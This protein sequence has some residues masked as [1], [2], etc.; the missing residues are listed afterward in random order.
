MEGSRLIATEKIIAV[1]SPGCENQ[2]EGIRHWAS[3]R[4][5]GF[6][7]I[8]T[9]ENFEEVKSE[10]EGGIV[11]ITIGGDGT[12]LEGARIFSPIRIP[13]IGVGSGTLSF[14]A[15]VE[16]EGIFDALEEI[17]A[18]ESKIDELQRV[19]VKIDSFEAEGLNEVVIGHIWPKKPIE[20]KISSIDVFVEG[21]H[22]GKYEGTGVAITTP[23]GSTGLS[24]SAGGPIHHPVL[25][26]TIQLTPL[27]T[28]NIG[29]RPLVFGAETELKII[30]DTEVYV[31]VDG[32]RAT[33]LL[34]TKKVITITGSKVPAYLINTSQSRGFFNRLGTNL[35]WGIR[36]QIGERYQMEKDEEKRFEETVLELA[37]SVAKGA[38]DVLREL[39]RKNEIQ[40]FENSKG[41][42]V[43]EADYLSENII[44]S[45]IRNKFPDH[46]IVS[47]ETVWEDKNSK[48]RWVIDPLD[49]T[50]N[51]I[52]RN[53]NYAVSV[54]LLEENEPLVGV[55]YI[56]EIDQ[57]YSAVRGGDAMVN[58][59]VIATTDRGE[60][61]E[62]ML[63]TGHD[64]KGELLS[65]LYPMV[66]GVRRHGSA[67]INLAYLAC[68][69]A[70]IVW[71]WDT[72]PWDVAA[73]ILMVRCS[74]GKVTGKN[75]EEY[76]LDFENDNINEL[77][78]SNGQLHSNILEEIN[79]G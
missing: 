58:G 13:F 44:T 25:N 24:L 23:T 1:S 66:K 78:A 29:V 20:R 47:E 19:S 48:Y 70:D 15:R 69:S 73:G 10:W 57:L 8:E 79:K 27:H 38:G 61:K 11:G 26:E 52:H 56:P 72:S 64:P 4:G 2:V 22:V 68:G 77:L 34:K 16:P 31:L 51:F 45:L 3:E 18:G 42:M 46:D 63:I 32:G 17:F 12:F 5:I 76:V 43:T 65:S 35:G 59:K 33:N 74:G 40:V 41:G 67:A 71:E 7:A 6:L 9:G 50:G 39:H 49:G 55:I 54:A 28:H 14:L 75:G 21:E 30:P 53:P 62:S 36:D 37:E 60:I